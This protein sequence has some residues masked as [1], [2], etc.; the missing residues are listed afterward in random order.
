MSKKFAKYEITIETTD[1]EQVNL[2][3]FLF[4]AYRLSFTC[5]ESV[6]LDIVKNEVSDKSRLNWINQ[7]LKGKT[8]SDEGM[9]RIN[10]YKKIREE[11]SLTA[12]KIRSLEG[13]DGAEQLTE[14]E[15]K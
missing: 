15:D 13:L 11:K 9:E 8:S 3:R 14:T 6:W 5:F 2:Q 1:D 4:E 10:Y 7:L 12:N